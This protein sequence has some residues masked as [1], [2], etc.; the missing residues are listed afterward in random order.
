MPNLAAPAT[1][2]GKTAAMA[3]TT[4]AT[5]ILTNVLDSGRTMRVVALYVSNVDGT[6]NS[7]VTVDVF[8]NATARHLCKTV[9]I[10]TGATL[11]TIT[12][13]DPLY[14]VEGDSLR[15]TA[16]A[17]GDLEAVVSYEEIS[18]GSPP[19]PPPT[20]VLLRFNGTNGSTNFVDSS[21]NG[22]SVVALTGASQ[23]STAQSVAGGSSGFFPAGAMLSSGVYIAS[24]PQFALLTNDFTFDMWVRFT[25]LPTEENDHRG[26]FAIDGPGSMA[27]YL[28]ATNSGTAL[29][30]G[31]SGASYPWSPS[32][33]QWYH[34]A[35]TR[36]DGAVRTFIDGAQLGDAFSASN[37]MSQGI[38][39][40]GTLSGAS[41]VGGYMDNFRLINGTAL[42][43]SNFTPPTDI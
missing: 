40:V 21:P 32:I 26:L 10:P 23:I 18:D 24:Q 3:V 29:W 13:A 36:Q 16:S 12:R 19:P 2:T 37:S 14:L 33:D 22:F 9:S 1:I 27:A 30:V 7:S 28:A 38:L 20:T 35:I 15:L 39:Y 8:R 42:Y 41:D 11:T 43:T 25:S 17:N 5:A 4:T 31:G 6:N 34:V